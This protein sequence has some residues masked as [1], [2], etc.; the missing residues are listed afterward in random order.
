MD[1]AN[2]LLRYESVTAGHTLAIK[3]LD[4]AIIEIAYDPVHDILYGV[5]GTNLYRIAPSGATTFILSLP[6]SSEWSAWISRPWG[7][8]PKYV[9]QEAAPSSGCKPTMATTTASETRS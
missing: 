1:E 2:Q 6:G 8:I 5:Q 7:P 4:R 9:P 3:P